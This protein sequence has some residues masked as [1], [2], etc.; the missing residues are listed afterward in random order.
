M[1]KKHTEA[2]AKVAKKAHR[3]DRKLSK[4]V[5]EARQ[6]RPVRIAAAVTELADQ[7]PLFAISAATIGYGLLTHNRT[8]TRAGVRMLASEAI[9]TGIKTA[10]KRSID[11]TRPHAEQAG[12]PYRLEK[13]GSPEHDLSSF[14]SGH[15][16]GAVAVARAITREAADLTPA[17][18]AGA[19]VVGAMQLPN[20]KHYASDVIAGAL[21]GLASEWLADAALGIAERGVARIRR[22]SPSASRPDRSVPS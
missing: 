7:P 6:H 8:V 18:A 21:I 13:G 22:A 10:I 3:L 20:A 14:P 5:G 19:A 15:T 12:K 11:R 1:A 9:A 17:A 4:T 2:A 16:A